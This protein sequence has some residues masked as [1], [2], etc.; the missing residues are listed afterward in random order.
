LND[1]KWILENVTFSIQLPTLLPVFDSLLKAPKLKRFKDKEGR[2]STLTVAINSFSY[3]NGI[4]DDPN[5]HGGGYV[6]D[7][8]VITNPG[9]IDEYKCLTGKDKPVVEFL[10]L[11]E[12]VNEFLSNAFSLVDMSVEK[13]EE[14]SFNH[15]MVSFGCTGGIHRSVYCAERLREHLRESHA[16]QVSL[17][18]REL[19]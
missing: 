11:Q 10:N 18:H 12:D 19:D 5:G 4:P 14:R 7:S 2:K 17:W 1:L 13:Y 3:K 16:V 6:F 9:K 8:R 15:L